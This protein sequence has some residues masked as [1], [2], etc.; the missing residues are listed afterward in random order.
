[1]TDYYSDEELYNLC[2]IEGFTDEVFPS[3]LDGPINYEALVGRLVDLEGPELF[4]AEY[5]RGVIKLPFGDC[6]AFRDA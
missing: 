4:Y 2:E 6:V 5:D 1:V 3:G